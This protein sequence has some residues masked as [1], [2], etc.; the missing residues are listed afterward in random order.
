MRLIENMR[1][2][3]VFGIVLVLL[4]TNM[5]TSTFNIWPA[6]A[7]SGTVYIRTDGSIDPPDAPI[8]TTD[9]ITYTLTGNI[10][11]HKDGIVVER[12][13]II[14]DG[15]GYTIQK[16]GDRE[17]YGV[18]LYGS[19]VTIKN[20]NIK[21]YSAGIYLDGS[22]YNSI[23][24]NNIANSRYG[25]HL[26]RSS[27]NS[28]YG[29][30]FVDAGL[31]VRYSYMNFVENNTVNGRPL[32]FLEGVSD[33][34][35][36]D[37]GQVI[38]VKCNNIR[39]ENL[40]LSRTSIG[41]QLWKTNNTIISGNN[42]ANNTTGIVLWSSSNNSIYG[43]SITNNYWAGIFLF[44]SSNNSIYGNSIVNNDRVG[45]YLCKSSNNSIY[46]NYFIDNA[47]QVYDCS[48]DNPYY[49]HSINVWDD[50]YPSGGN[51]WSD[52]TDVDEKK[53]PRQDQPGN[54]GIWDH[55][56]VIDE[57]NVDRY[58][59]VNPRVSEGKTQ[60]KLIVF[61]SCLS[62][63][64]LGVVRVSSFY[65]SPNG[66]LGWLAVPADVEISILCEGSL[67]EA[68]TEKRIKGRRIELLIDGRAVSSHLSTGEDTN[69][70]FTIP[71]KL[72]YGLHKL[73]VRF[74]GDY[75]YAPSIRDFKIIA[76]RSSGFNITRD[77][78]RF[79]NQPYSFS[80]HLE[81]CQKLIEDGI[82]DAA[83]RTPFLM[84]FPFLSATGHCFG[85][86]ASSSVYFVEQSLKPEPVDTYEMSW[87]EAVWEINLYHL[88]QIKW[89]FSEAEK[90]ETALEEVKSLIGSGIPVVLALRAPINHA[91]T[92]IGYCEQ[93]N[94]T[95]LIAYDSNFSNSTV[96]R[97]VVDGNI[98]YSKRSNVSEGIFINP[99]ALPISY[100]TMPNLLKEM[101]KRFFGI[102]V[103]SP[104]DIKITSESGKVLLVQNDTILRNDFTEG[105]FYITQE[106][107][108]FLLPSNENYQLVTVGTKEGKTDIECARTVHNQ[109]LI[110]EYQNITVS[111]GTKI[112]LPTLS[113]EKAYVDTNGDGTFDQKINATIQSENPFVSLYYELLKKRNELLKDYQRLNS[114]YHELLNAYE[115]LNSTYTTLQDS[116]NELQSKQ[117]TIKN[118]L[119]NT[120]NLMYTFMATTIIL[121]I[122]TICL[123]K[124]RPK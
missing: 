105:Y 88:S 3:E 50:G 106:E 99:Y 84:L 28:I 65:F 46:H 23:Y 95:F 54:D 39:V 14:L 29:N 33:Y 18:H 37:A 113:S 42:I 67:C 5:L 108:I 16:I 27:N 117:E 91:I 102:Y 110:Y 63:S 94:E 93:S 55:P 124:R 59:L 109:L 69:V 66:V 47:R 11:S 24:G 43:N 15:A 13:N 90:V 89:W 77:A 38:L 30:M 1:R 34:S 121:I 118:E 107:K 44:F 116:Y 120:R 81:L 98:L 4:L 9:Y 20:I 58:P 119:I 22:S 86:A 83:L 96:I 12:N 52:Y 92:I 115:Q 80:E 103:H 17:Y 61:L 19:N 53:G 114:T 7:W 62:N 68:D 40:N 8:T 101:F 87:S 25:I 72:S 97:S 82:L 31:V 21:N 26:D 57:N 60:T 74:N 70:N 6:R 56:Y 79:S 122:T 10:T 73:E 85:M 64:S 75:K 48:W 112:C 71:L 49:T 41:I 104:L 32:V 36:S 2:K 123:A 100:G 45:I 35:V 51:Y 111:P 78:Y 76:Y